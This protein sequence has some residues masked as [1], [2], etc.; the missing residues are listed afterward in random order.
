MIHH[1]NCSSRVIYLH[2]NTIT[3][4][5]TVCVYARGPEYWC[6]VV[7]V[8]D[9]PAQRRPE[10]TAPGDLQHLAAE[11]EHCRQGP[12]VRGNPRIE[13]GEEFVGSRER[14]R[15]K[16]TGEEVQLETWSNWN[17]GPGGCSVT[18]SIV[19]NFPGH[20]STHSIRTSGHHCRLQRVGR[21]IEDNILGRRE[22]GY[23]CIILWKLYTVLFSSL[24]SMDSSWKYPHANK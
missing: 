13:G 3:E 24:Y 8:F 17:I 9:S 10:E 16:E 4:P 6:S 19:W 14:G 20:D 23:F 1:L 22:Q 7:P 21:Y 12:V 18:V 15:D 2:E 5:L 11:K